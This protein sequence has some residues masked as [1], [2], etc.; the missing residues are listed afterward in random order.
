[1]DG[2]KKLH[3]LIDKINDEKNCKVKLIY[4]DTYINLFAP[5]NIIINKIDSM[6]ENLKKIIDKDTNMGK[7]LKETKKD[8]MDYA[9]GSSLRSSASV[10]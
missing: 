5:K 10:L 2:Y 6:S 9:K 3:C 4:L 1:M 8:L 7:E